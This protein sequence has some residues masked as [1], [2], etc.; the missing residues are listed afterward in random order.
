MLH[1]TGTPLSRSEDQRSRSRA[2]RGHIVAASRLQLVVVEN[3]L[4]SVEVV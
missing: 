4:R 2:R 1:V 3:G